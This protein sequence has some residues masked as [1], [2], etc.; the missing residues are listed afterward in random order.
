[1]FGSEIRVQR[2]RIDD[3][4]AV[5]T[6]RHR[7]QER[8]GITIRNAQRMEIRYNPS[9]IDEREGMIE[10]K[11]VDRAGNPRVGDWEVHRSLRQVLGSL[12]GGGL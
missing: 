11:S 5:R 2:G 12:G 1:M 10:L 3:V 8:G 9:G 4:I 7:R 6:S